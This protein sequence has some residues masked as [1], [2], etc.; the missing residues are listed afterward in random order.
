[1]ISFSRQTIILFSIVIAILISIRPYHV[2]ADTKVYAGLYAMIVQGTDVFTEIGVRNLIWL[3]GR[4]FPNEPTVFFFIVAFSICSAMLFACKKVLQGRDELKYFFI[5]ASLILFSSWFFTF[6]TNALQQGLA[7]SIFYFAWFGGIK[8][9]KAFGLIIMLGYFIHSSAYLLL[10][11][12]LLIQISGF[13]LL[14]IAILSIVGYW[15]GINELII[16][17]V[18]E[19]AAIPLYEFVK[20]YTLRSNGGVGQ[21]VGFNWKFVAYTIIWPVLIFI[22]QRFSLINKKEGEFLLRTY[23]LAAL[24]FLWLGF[25][26]FANRFALIAWWLVPVCMTILIARVKFSSQAAGIL[27]ASSIYF[28]VQL[29]LGLF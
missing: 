16:K 26:P 8:K 10:P 3:I 14:S 11:I 15:S 29:R 28:F 2:G 17:S 20:N 25:G 12:P 6:S 21:Y 19:M 18:S 13:K 9:L 7:L 23:L 1:M 27:F 5:S 4:I 22:F 24:P